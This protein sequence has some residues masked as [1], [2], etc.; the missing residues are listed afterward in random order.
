MTSDR[1]FAASSP[2]TAPS[3]DHMLLGMQFGNG[4]GSQPHAWRAP[5]TPADA[6]M[7]FDVQVRHAQ[8]AERGLFDFLFLP[9]FLDLQA[10]LS[11]EAPMITLE[12]C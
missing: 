1:P 8:A 4:C 10:D 9:D 11:H 3:P 12:R 7:D 6:F 5:G 2:S